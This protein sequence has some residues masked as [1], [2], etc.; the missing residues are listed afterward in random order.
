MRRI[1]AIVRLRDCF[2][3]GCGFVQRAI[4]EVDQLLRVSHRPARVRLVARCPMAVV[5]CRNRVTMYEWR[6]QIG[7]VYL[8][9]PSAV[10]SLQVF[11]VPIR[12]S[13]QPQEKGDL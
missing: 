2:G 11:A 10:P 4:A 12:G 8:S 3:E 6:N 5:G 13:G 1:P 7:W 9:R